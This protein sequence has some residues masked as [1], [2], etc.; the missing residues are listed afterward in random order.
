MSNKDYQSVDA[1]LP[2]TLPPITRREAEKARDRIYRKFGKL[3]SGYRIKPYRVRRCW[4]SP[5]Q[6]TG[7]HKG[8]GRLIHDCSHL[9]FRRVY[10]HKLPHDPLHVHYE[11]EIAKYVAGSGWLDGSLRPKLKPKQDIKVVR[12]ERMV[13]RER[14]WSA[15]QNRAANALAKVRKEIRAYQKRHPSTCSAR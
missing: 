5:T 14:E 8:W 15:K 13:K 2:D 7:H 6:T 4:L 10:P 3:D 1:A 11:T 9:I 12:F